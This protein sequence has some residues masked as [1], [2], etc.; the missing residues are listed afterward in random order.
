MVLSQLRPREG[1]R[2]FTL[3]ELL[4]VIAII[5]ILIGLLLP[6]VQKV[7]EAAARMKCTNNLKQI[8]LGMHNYND[9]Y[10]RLPAGWVTSLAFKPN[11]GWSWGT[12]ILPFIEQDNAYR[13]LNPDTNALTA[14]IPPLTDPVAGPIYIMKMPM[15]RCPSD[16][17]GLD[18]NA[19]LGGWGRGNYVCNREVLGPDVSNNPSFMTVATI[20][21][22][23]SNTILVGERDSVRNIAAT[24]AVRSNV[25]SAS[26]EGRPG[27]GLNIPYPGS[28][29]SPTSTSA[30]ERLGFNS[31]HTGGVN[32]LLG[33]GHVQFIRNSVQA[34]Q[35]ADHCAFPA[36]T[37]N[38]TWQN[39]IH[40][41]DGNPIGDF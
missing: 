31:L 17:V 19:L 13:I 8:G 4:V 16:G 30:C 11:P 10:Y 41:S 21:D 23:S 40:P 12:L 29:P 33:D 34:D 24:W 26:F 6:A 28:P 15:Y 9:T 7:R 36:A 3:I 39:L 25:T 35:T 1:R 38:F 27:R 14:T 22:G 2:G 37:G 32:F 18:T 5:A 20:P